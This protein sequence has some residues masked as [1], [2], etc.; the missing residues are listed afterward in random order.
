MI[1]PGEWNQRWGGFEGREPLSYIKWYLSLCCASRSACHDGSGQVSVHQ[2]WEYFWL[3]WGRSILVS[4]AVICFCPRD[5]ITDESLLKISV[6]ETILMTTLALQP[7]VVPKCIRHVLVNCHYL[8]FAT[9]GPF[10]PW[11]I[12]KPVKC[13]RKC[14]FHLSKPWL[15]DWILG[16][17]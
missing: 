3:C 6:G 2:S 4:W 8:A 10:Q 15:R 7:N 5:L 9:D 11:W 13:I 16:L 12:E 17:F 14:S 1:T